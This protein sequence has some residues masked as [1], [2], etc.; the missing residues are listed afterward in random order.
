MNSY[1]HSIFN[2]LISISSLARSTTILSALKHFTIHII[3]SVFLT[4]VGLRVYILRSLLTPFKFFNYQILKPKPFYTVAFYKA[5]SAAIIVLVEFHEDSTS[6]IFWGARNFRCGITDFICRVGWTSVRSICMLSTS[7]RRNVLPQI[8][9][10]S[11][12]TVSTKKA[13]SCRDD[14]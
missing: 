10:H 8:L 5:C 14:L 6:M 11:N 2:F 1:Y 3:W 12:Q 13:S 4:S 9:P 7:C